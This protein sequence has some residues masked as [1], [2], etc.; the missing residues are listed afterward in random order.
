MPPKQ[1]TI[2][3]AIDELVASENICAMTIWRAAD[4][5]RVSTKTMVEALRTR[6]I[7]DDRAVAFM[8]KISGQDYEMGFGS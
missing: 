7:L 6:D 4:Q 2:Q 1:K 3:E 5:A 8:R